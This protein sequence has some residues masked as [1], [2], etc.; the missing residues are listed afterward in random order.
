MSNFIKYNKIKNKFQKCKTDRLVTRWPP[1]QVYI[2]SCYNTNIMLSTINYNL[3]S[4][5]INDVK[6]SSF[7]IHEDYSILR[8]MYLLCGL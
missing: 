5:V 2:F 4:L 7:I 6:S 8:I 3:L 1:D